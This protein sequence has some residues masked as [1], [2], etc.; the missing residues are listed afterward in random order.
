M[1]ITNAQH[2]ILNR[3]A[4]AVFALEDAILAAKKTILSKSYYPEEAIDRL[5][6]Y[7]NIVEQQ[8]MLFPV[9]TKNIESGK[10]DEL[11]LQ[12]QKVNGLSQLIRDD[13]K[14]LLAILA[15]PNAKFVR[16]DYN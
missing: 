14:E 4:Q 9:I 6:H 11:L 3:L 15:N 10:H 7:M 2:E 12:V 1:S 8:K 16:P 13:A 5:D